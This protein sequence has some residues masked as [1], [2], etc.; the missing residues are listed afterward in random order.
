MAG[1]RTEPPGVPHR[2][3]PRGTQCRP[4]HRRIA[5]V[6][7]ADRLRPLRR[8]TSRPTPSSSPSSTVRTAGGPGGRPRPAASGRAPPGRRCRRAA[9][10]TGK[11]DEVSR[12]PPCPAVAAP[13]PGPRR[14]GHAADGRRA[15]RRRGPAPRRRRRDPRARPN[16]A[17]VAL[18]AARRRR[19][20]VAAVAEGACSAPTC[21]RCAQPRRQGRQA[22]VSAVTV[23]QRRRPGQG[24]PQGRRH[25]GR[26]PRPRP[27]TYTRD[28]VNTRPR[29]LPPDA[30]PTRSGAERQGQRGQ[31]RRSWTRRRSPRAATAA[32]SASG[33]ARS[34][35]RG[36]SS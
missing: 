3:V 19:R 2:A 28:L 21:C 8:A 16:A 11:A 23:A 12:S 24:G 31:G 22:A 29:A 4:P 7:T 30:S 9:R 14:A 17:T 36:W 20:A 26:D 35:R 25:A 1:Y 27:S 18:V 15:V 32:S 5:V 33:R 10:V 34:T 13:R 6:T